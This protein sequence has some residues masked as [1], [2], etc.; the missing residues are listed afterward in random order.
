[1]TKVWEV[2]ITE[3]ISD[4][5]RWLVGFFNRKQGGF[6]RALTDSDIIWGDC[7]FSGLMKADLLAHP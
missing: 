6:V 1:M 2:E 3:A 5:Y 7:A 4:G